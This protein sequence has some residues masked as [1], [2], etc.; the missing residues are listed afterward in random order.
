MC[1]G[2]HGAPS[3]WATENN[4][5]TLASQVLGLQMCTPTPGSCLG[6]TLSF[7][8]GHEPPLE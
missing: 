7:G 4:P 3:L 5:P 8:K 2:D 1:W 6:L